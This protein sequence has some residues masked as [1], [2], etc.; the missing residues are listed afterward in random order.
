MKTVLFMCMFV[1]VTLSAT[2]DV[3]IKCITRPDACSW[4]TDITVDLDLDQSG[5][6]MGGLTNL[7]GVMTL[8]GSGFAG[9]SESYFVKTHPNYSNVTWSAQSLYGD[10]RYVL[11]YDWSDVV[12]VVKTGRFTQK[13]AEQQEERSADL[14]CVRVL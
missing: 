8:K 12:G 7:S 6:P 3:Q 14:I 5:H 13:N 11:T 4:L 1:S 9:G 10:K 2:P